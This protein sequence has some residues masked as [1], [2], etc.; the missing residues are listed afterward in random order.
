MFVSENDKSANTPA[1]FFVILYSKG[2]EQTRQ[3][4]LKSHFMSHF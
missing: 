4:L 2:N 3:H 1:T